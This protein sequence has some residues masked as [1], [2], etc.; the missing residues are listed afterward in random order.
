MRLVV[1]KKVIFGDHQLI[2]R[3]KSCL[4]AIDY[5]TLAIYWIIVFL[6]CLGGLLVITDSISLNFS[7]FDALE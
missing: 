1:S 6:E 3:T 2:K 7:T 4:L 5:Y